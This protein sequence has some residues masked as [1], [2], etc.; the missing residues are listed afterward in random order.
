MIL[1]VVKHGIIMGMGFGMTS[2]RKYEN[3]KIKVK[4]RWEVPTGHKEDRKVTTFDHRPKRQ[5]SR[6]DVDKAWRNEYDMQPC[7]HSIMAITVDL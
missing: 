4:K 1:I 2:R 6:N 5:R 3:V 7:P